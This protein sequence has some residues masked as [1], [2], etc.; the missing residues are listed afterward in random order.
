MSLH[1]NFCTGV[2]QD[3]EPPTIT[4]CPIDD[5]VESIPFGDSASVSWIEPTAEDNSGMVTRTKTHEPGFVVEINQSVLV[6]YT[7]VDP[8]GNAATCTFRISVIRM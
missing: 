2:A 4:G 1:S 3:V 8:S 6:T 7:F 5:I